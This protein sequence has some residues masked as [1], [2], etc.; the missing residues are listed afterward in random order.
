L[1]KNTWWRHS[2]GLTQH[3]VCLALL[4][5]VSV[6]FFAP[7]HFSGGQL[8]GE[9]TVNWRATNNAPIEYRHETGR[10]PLWNTNAFG[11][12]PSYLGSYKSPVPQ[13]DDLPNLLRGFLWPTSHFI[14]LLFGTYGLVFFLTRNKGAGLLAAVGYGLTTYLPI[15]L[16]AGHNTKFIAL[17]FA[18][19]MAWAFAWTLRRPRL[20]SGLAFAVALAANLRAGHIQITYY[21]TFLLGLWW[22][23]E[24]AGAVRHWQ[25]SQEG[26][27]QRLKSFG[28]ATGWLALGSVL[29]LMM[30]AQ[31]YLVQA[32]YKKYSIRGDATSEGGSDGLE[33]DYAMRWSQGAGE[34]ITLA[35]A[36]AYGGSSRPVET[37]SGTRISRYWGPKPF[38][39][40]P[41]YVGGIVLFLALLAVWKERRRNVVKAFGLGALL[42][43]L[44]ALGR[45]FALLNDLMLAYFPLFDA[46]RAPETWMSMVAFAL[47]VLAGLGAD[48]AYRRGT[49]QT[50]ARRRSRAVYVSAGAVAALVA[51]LY[52]GRGTFFDFEK[53]GRRQKVR[54][55]VRRQVQTQVNQQPGL[56]MNSPRVQ[57]AVE[58]NVE[59]YMEPRISAREDAFAGDALRTLLFLA[60]ALGAL[61]LYRRGTLPR[62]G[63]AAALTLLVAFDLGG[64]GRRYINSDAV[65]DAPDAEAQIQR[66]GADEFIRK[67]RRAAGGKGRFRVAD[68]VGGNPMN[69]ARTS[70][71]HESIGGYHGAKLQRYQ[72]FIDHVFR[73]P[74]DGSVN[75]NALDLMSARYVIAPR[76]LP[77]T[78]VVYQGE[79][80]RAPSVLKNPDALP[81]AFFVGETEVME[82]A[83]ATWE[84]LRSS[85]FNARRTAL[86]SK[87]IEG[88]QVTPLDSASTTSVQLQEY[89]PRKIIWQVQTDAPR[90]FVASETYYPAGWNAY[91]D[92]ELVEIRR[93]DY[94]LR[95]V[96]VPAGKHRLVMRF[97][98]ARHHAGLW[99]SSV[100][101]ALVY[102]LAL[103]LVGRA[104]WHRR[105][106]WTGKGEANHDDTKRD[107]GAARPP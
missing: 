79:G 36:N 60:L 101:T 50:K 51:L 19:W 55:Q 90:L 38:T 65:T 6:A 100:S 83:E 84:R 53:E 17:A 86:L 89:G 13:I 75:E 61:W 74:Q 27:R 81:R 66:Y 41:H 70:Y 78:Q 40:G 59:R 63:V 77:G 28:K 52:V 14:F 34:L 43:T 18:P 8:I 105:E 15:I 107:G 39:E 88:F 33:S 95:A 62:W 102:G 20:L 56:S 71:F 49:N 3:L 30:V 85:S 12:M 96:P 26:E 44:F 58:Q 24:A 54:Q 99:I 5:V 92:G 76:R 87:P 42:M 67:K 93:A 37:E 16:T 94:L 98:P 29:G 64:V 47:A 23:V 21:L 45:H 57:R 69:Q 91:L 97:E 103:V 106:R 9:D 1:N 7:L 46:F 48:Y 10:E 72:D 80:R 68:F 31:P 25:G 82:S 104:A 11:G 22:L 32:E 73:S 2:S 4:L 35:V